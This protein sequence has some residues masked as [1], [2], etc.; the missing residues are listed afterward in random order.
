MTAAS[1]I[2]LSFP[3]AIKVGCLMVIKPAERIA[4][5]QTNPDQTAAERITV[6]L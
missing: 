6:Y 2:S 3:S 1:V 5:L 4:N